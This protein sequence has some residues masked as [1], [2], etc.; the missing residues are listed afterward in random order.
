MEETGRPWQELYKSAL[1]ELEKEKLAAAIE[2]A[3]QAIDARLRE[4]E[5]AS[6]QDEDELRALNDALHTLRVLSRE[7]K[8]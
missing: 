6:A 2:T 5:H 1:L 8:K 4:L 7:L 3:H